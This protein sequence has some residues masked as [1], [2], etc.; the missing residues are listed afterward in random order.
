M[1]YRASGWEESVTIGPY[2]QENES[3]YAKGPE[4]MN[5]GNNEVPLHGV[6]LFRGELAEVRDLLVSLQ[7]VLPHMKECSQLHDLMQEIFE[8]R[9]G[10]NKLEQGLL[11]THLR[12][13]I[14]PG[15]K[16]PGEV[17]LA[18]SQLSAMRHGAIIAIEQ[19]DNLDALLQGGEIVDAAVGAAMLES[20]FYPGGPLHDGAVLIRDARIHKAG[21]LLPL[22]TQPWG[23]QTIGLGTRHR[24][25]VGLS[26]RS[27][28]LVIVVSEEKG[29][30]SLALGG[31][32]YP[33]LDILTLLE[34]LGDILEEGKI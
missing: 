14:S 11:Q 29:W 19:E 25:A 32:L 13:C 6:K 5:Q 12:C 26:E 10:V 24:A 17:V 8:I 20:I 4:M 2:L 33:N 21:C 27:D 22:S 23:L 15:I 31:R 34:R 1:Q 30:I 9:E 28:A 7:K 18:V 16:V 3:T